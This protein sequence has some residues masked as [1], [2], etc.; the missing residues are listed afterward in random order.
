MKIVLQGPAGVRYVEE[1]VPYRLLPGEQVI[2]A[3]EDTSLQDLHGELAK[4]GLGLGDYVEKAF[5]ALPAAIRPEHCSR[6][7]KRK[8][9]LNR[10]KTI[11][12][13]AA[14][15]EALAVK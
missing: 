5:A 1:G 3:E 11:G 4:H 8:L 7:E 12:I 10:A 14:V 9:A 6:C 15:K 13:I 2:G